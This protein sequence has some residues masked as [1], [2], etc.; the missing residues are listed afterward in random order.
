MQMSVASTHAPGVAAVS[1]LADTLPKPNPV[2]SPNVDF[3]KVAICGIE[4]VF[5]PVAVEVVFELDNSLPTVGPAVADR[6]DLAVGDSV[7]AVSYGGV[8]VPSLVRARRT[9]SVT[10][11]HAERIVLDAVSNNGELD[12]ERKPVGQGHGF[13]RETLIETVELG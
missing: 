10:A 8:K 12:R 13:K 6:Y 3:R 7:A 5:A 2:A 11:Y 4:L 1:A 9:V